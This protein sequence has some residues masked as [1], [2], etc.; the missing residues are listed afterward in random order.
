MTEQREKEGGGEER[1][2]G[3]LTGDGA[4]FPTAAA[5]DDGC[6]GCRVQIFSSASLV[7][8]FVQVNMV[9]GS[10]V[11]ISCFGLGSRVQRSNP[12]NSGSTESQLGC[13]SP[14]CSAGS[15]FEFYKWEFRVR[16]W[17]GVSRGLGSC[18]G[19]MVSFG[20]VLIR[21]SRFESYHEA[22]QLTRS[23]R[24][25]P[26]NSVKRFGSA[27]SGSRFSSTLFGSIIVRVNRS[28]L[29]NTGQ[30]RL[31]SEYCRMHASKSSLGNDST[32]L[33]LASFAHGNTGAIVK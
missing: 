16:F 6:G 7:R 12:T 23:N 27:N 14:G 21:V 18:S 19:V 25:N 3:R 4:V 31:N 29:V 33:Y 1:E 11:Q 20:S 2:R 5:S 17:I 28:A 26:V 8:S 32:K 15:R 22:V 30:L 13:G 24:V 9:N 10:S